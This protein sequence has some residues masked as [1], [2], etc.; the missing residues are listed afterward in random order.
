[1]I[2]LGI[3]GGGMYGARLTQIFKDADRAEKIKFCSVA[4][5][6]Q[7]VLDKL[8][9]EYGV[10]GYTDYREMIEKEGLNAIAVV[11][12]DYLHREIA[13][14]S[15]GKGLHML[16]QKPLDTTTGGAEN[17]VKAARDND[18]LLYVDFHK[19]FDPGFI[20]ARKQ[21]AE[22]V[23]GE[24]LYG[25]LNIEDTLYIPAEAFSGWAHLSSPAWFI[26][27]HL[28]DA[29][30]WVLGKAPVNVSA[31]GHKKKLTGMGIDTYDAL[32]A[33]LIYDCGAVITVDASWILPKMFPSPVNQNVRLIGTEGFIEIDGQDRGVQFWS[34]KADGPLKPMINNPYG[35]LESYNRFTDCGLSG[36]T[37]DSVL[38]FIKLLQKIDAGV[39]LDS[40]E[41]TYPNG[42]EAVVAT[43]VVEAIHQSAESGKIVEI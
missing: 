37:V 21:L 31:I 40:L 17:I 19:R 38:Y 32:N 6:S 1:M 34:E 26:G 11:T 27:I 43:R 15:A 4:D 7:P 18:V 36:Y 12:P 23:Y 29:L 33:R 14:Y 5:I 3:V 16:V 35:Y 24:L 25:Y 41:G 28:I 30:N 42:G 9:A 8:T 10:N 13:V 22:G 39:T 20:L 2:R